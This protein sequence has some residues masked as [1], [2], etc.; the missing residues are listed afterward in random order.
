MRRHIPAYA[1]FYGLKFRQA[2]RHKH[3]RALVL[4]ARKSIGLFVGLLHRKE[5]YRSQEG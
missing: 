2:T 4:T 1:R 5:A 3:K